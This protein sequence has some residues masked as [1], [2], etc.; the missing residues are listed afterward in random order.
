MARAHKTRAIDTWP[1]LGPDAD[2]KRVRLYSIDTGAA[3]PAP[4]P[5]FES[6]ELANAAAKINKGRVVGFFEWYHSRG[7]LPLVVFE[8]YP[9]ERLDMIDDTTGRD[10]Y[11][12]ATAT[13]A[14]REKRNAAKRRSRRELTDQQ[15]EAHNARQLTRYQKIKA[16]PDKYAALLKRT[17]ENQKKW[18]DRM[19][20]QERADY[21]H[22]VHQRRK[23]RSADK[24][25]RSKRP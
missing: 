19:T 16:D 11:E 23:I 9:V 4:P 5:V 8:R 24:K 7:M 1:A 17:R 2:P 22:M 20:P 3:Q 12:A 25:P 18:L 10:R 21:W 14:K 13:P 15:R 6:E